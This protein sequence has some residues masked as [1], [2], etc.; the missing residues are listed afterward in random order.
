[1][2]RANSLLYAVFICLVIG[3]MLMG[4][5]Y[6]ASLSKQ[7]NAFY[8]SYENLIISNE[9]A[10]NYSLKNLKDKDSIEIESNNSLSFSKIKYHGIYNWVEVVSTNK[11]DTVTSN[12]MIN[13][14]TQNKIGLYV[15]A[16]SKPIY[17]FGKI[18]VSGTIH[19]P[20]KSISST[21]V[22]GIANNSGI[23]EKLILES[24]EKLPTI[25]S[26]IT[27]FLNEITKLKD[28]KIEFISKKYNS[29][30]NK[31]IV[32]GWQQNKLYNL[33]GNIILYAKD[34][35]NISK[36][37][38]LDD[39]II[40]SQK[41]T[42]QSGFKGSIQV[43]ANEVINVQKNVTLNFPSALILNNQAANIGKLIIEEKSKILGPIICKIGSL[44]NY[45]KNEVFISK[46]CFILGD[47]YCEG[48]LCLNSN[49]FGSVITTMIL[50][51]LGDNLHYNT[52]GNVS[53]NSFNNAS[54]YNC[55][56]VLKNKTVEY[57]VIKKVY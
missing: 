4:I 56:P 9:S 11:K 26:K 48:K 27:S 10:L 50:S 53:V 28:S 37:D 25:N 39:I 20:F 36:V 1:M 14:I 47:I 35:I 31:S 18:N 54:Y 19:L 32:I 21:Y 46:D 12:Y 33:R 8:L 34:S 13:K 38:K 24:E 5:V 52:L 29:F 3:I 45:E 6:F 23:N 42:I 44:V 16:I 49:V 2:V 17:Y 43:V 40:V 41:V 15:S 7:L 51:N 30:K 22:N 57:E 55:F